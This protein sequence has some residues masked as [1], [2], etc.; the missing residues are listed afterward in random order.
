MSFPRILA[1]PLAGT[2]AV[3]AALCL[4]VIPLHRLT[5]APPLVAVH[6]V[7]TAAARMDIPAVLRVKLLAPAQRVV[8]KNTDGIILL[9]LSNLPAGESERDAVLHL[10]GDAV[11]L[12]VRADFGDSAAETAVFLTVLPDAYEERTCYMTGTGTLE[13]TLRF[14]WHGH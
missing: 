1:S 3:I 7:E 8:V 12:V 9:V 6:T 11:E 4:L 13:E 10:A 14:T 5:S 2:A